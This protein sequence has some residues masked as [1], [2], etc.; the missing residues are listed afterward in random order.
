MAQNPSDFTDHETSESCSQEQSVVTDE[1]SSASESRDNLAVS[2]TQEREEEAVRGE[3]QETT[4]S[5]VL[6]EAFCTRKFLCTLLALCL[7]AVS[8]FTMHIDVSVVSQEK[9][10]K[11]VPLG[12]FLLSGAALLMVAV[13]LGYAIE[14]VTFRILRG[15]ASSTSSVMFYAYNCAYHISLGCALGGLLVCNMLTIGD[16][17]IPNPYLFELRVRVVLPMT[18]LF[19]CFFALQ[20]CLTQKTVFGFNYS[21][22]LKRIRRAIL[23]DLFVTLMAC[24]SEFRNETRPVDFEEADED[25]VD[26]SQIFVARRKQRAPRKLATYIFEKQFQGSSRAPMTFGAK[27]TLLNEFSTLCRTFR[28]TDAS[29]LSILARLKEKAHSKAAA[30]HRS[31]K[32]KQMRKMGD[33]G[34]VFK[35]QAVFNAFFEQMGVRKSD[36]ITRDFLEFFI[37]KSLKEKYLI[38]YSLRQLHAAIER[39]SLAVQVLICVVYAICT[40]IS[41]MGLTNSM[42]GIASTIFGI[43]I[44]ASL[45]K[46]HLVNPIMFLFVIHPYDVGD[47]VLVTL[48]GKQENLVVSTLNVFSTHFFRWDGTCFF[49][50]NSVL[51]ATPICNIRRSGPCMENHVVQ[52]STQTDPQKIAELKRRLQHFV[53]KYPIYY[54][55]YVLVNYERIDDSNK[56]HVKVLMQYKTNIQNYEHYL[57]LRSNFVCYMNKQISSLGISYELPLQKISL[58]EDGTNGIAKS[59]R[60]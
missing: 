51:S 32:R 27:F 33:F 5:E 12:F 39:V 37:E 53:K 29:I 15:S 13:V 41:G 11:Q 55:D 22:Y 23:M 9:T 25:W 26:D 56:L 52:V 6:K 40:V 30:L 57:S 19:L 3:Y 42:G 59:A 49:V 34:F 35:R 45:L 20:R 4:I 14:T 28:R 43:P 8:A 18:I 2:S 50:P 38:S 31:L 16:F 60:V 46:E 21:T 54:S 48:D 17:Y 44:I 58:E 10:L 47:R 1:T 36:E 24:V 7:A